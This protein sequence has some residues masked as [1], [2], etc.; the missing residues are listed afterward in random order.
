M[1][2][3]FKTLKNIVIFPDAIR[4]TLH[5]TALQAHVIATIENRVIERSKAK[6]GNGAHSLN[7]Q[8]D[9]KAPKYCDVEHDN[10]K[11]KKGNINIQF[12]LKIKMPYGSP[13]QRN[14]KPK[15][16]GVEECNSIDDT[17]KEQR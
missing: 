2:P 16:R 15:K 9:S 12:S 4:D 10:Y 13:L 11:N 5:T 3:S 17:F 14:C 7:H 8:H 1:F 6:K